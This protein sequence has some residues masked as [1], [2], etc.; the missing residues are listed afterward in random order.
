MNDSETAKS[1]SGMR[2]SRVCA[3]NTSRLAF[4]GSGRVERG[5]EAGLPSY[6][7][8]RFA[9]GK[10]Y[11]AD[12]NA[13]YNIGARYLVRAKLKSLPER[14]RLA[15]E[16]KVPGC[17]RRTTCTLSSLISLGAELAALATAQPTEPRPYAGEGSCLPK[18]GGKH[19]TSVA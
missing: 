1:V 7:T 14:E 16:A 9:T 11:D 18:A 10:T 4:D 13:A 5:R 3:W 19:A 6:S 8:V 2:I 15:V 17:A 12:L